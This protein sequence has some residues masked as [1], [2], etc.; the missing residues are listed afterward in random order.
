[1]QTDGGRVDLQAA[2]PGLPVVH[3]I[4]QQRLRPQRQQE[5]HK[6]ALAQWAFAGPVGVCLHPPQ[7]DVEHCGVIRHAQPLVEL[8]VHLA[9]VHDLQTAKVQQAGSTWTA[10]NRKG[11]G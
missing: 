2:R 3:A 4:E 6:H 10:C 11:L 9:A 8:E 5:Q 7:H 1:M